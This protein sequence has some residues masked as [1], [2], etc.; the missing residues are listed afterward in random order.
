M[1]LKN[2]KLTNFRGFSNVEQPLE[3]DHNVVLFYGRNAS[4][5]TSIFDAVELLLTG[6]IRRFQHIND[7]SSILVNARTP[8]MP[9]RAVLEFAGNHGPQFANAEIRSGD[10]PFVPPA[11]DRAESDLFPSVPTSVRQVAPQQLL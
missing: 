7:L 10:K 8:D 1:R 6:S 2:L 9:A 3:L 4:G 5:K 11:L